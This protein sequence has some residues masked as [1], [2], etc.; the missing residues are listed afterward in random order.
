MFGGADRLA[1]YLLAHPALAPF[2]PRLVHRSAVAFDSG[3][4]AAHPELA[5][6]AV[7]FPDR[8]EKIERLEA[9][10]ASKA[11]VI[12]AKIFWRLAE[13]ALFPWEVARLAAAFRSLGATLVHVNN[14]GYPGALG[15]R[16]AVVAAR[17]AGAQAVLVV[18]NQTRPSSL[19]RDLLE[20]PIDRLVAACARRFVTAT[21]RA[22]SSLAERGFP[23]AKLRIIR[24][25]V[26]APGAARSRFDVRRELGM[27]EEETA[28][29]M[30]ALFEPRKGHAVLVEAAARLHED[31]HA[32]RFVLIGDG[33]EK[34]RIE[35]L[36]RERGLEGRF[37]FLGFR[38]DSRDIVAACDG[39]VLPS[40]HSEDMPLAVLDAMALGRPVVSTRLAGIPEEVEHEVTGLLAEPGDARGLADAL[41][42]LTSEPAL[43]ARMGEAGRKRFDSNFEITA[44]ARA[45][46]G[47]YAELSQEC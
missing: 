16:A 21:R 41:R 34:S 46:A 14:G 23:A 39:F 4:A 22:S 20:W 26:P 36:V 40:I 15:C 29:C 3:L 33:A 25:G 17:L 18:H 1:V 44:M 37:L 10:G 42:L 6:V 2:A 12:A 38:E 13:L 7:S 35:A 28:W 32:P 30:T 43:R 11:G 24:D 31:G 19:P 5:S 27:S 8:V 45:Y 47:L 9:E